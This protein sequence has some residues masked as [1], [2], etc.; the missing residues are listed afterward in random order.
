[1]SLAE[2]QLNLDPVIVFS[3]LIKLGSSPLNAE[4]AEIISVQHL[5]SNFR[6]MLDDRFQFCVNIIHLQCQR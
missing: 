4:S 6:A 2:L 1:M 5:P 3:R